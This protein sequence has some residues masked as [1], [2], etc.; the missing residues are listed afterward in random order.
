M[1]SIMYINMSYDEIQ[2][3]AK[4]EDEKVVFEHLKSK[5]QIAESDTI[6]SMKIE[7]STQLILTLKHNE[8][9]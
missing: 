2:D 9:D 4:M 7:N 6:A 8:K 3:L 5:Y 1:E